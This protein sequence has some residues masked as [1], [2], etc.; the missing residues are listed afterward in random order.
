MAS[1]FQESSMPIYEYRCQSCGDTLEVLQ[2]MGS[3]KLRK[4]RKCSGKLERL[5]SRT[6]FHLKGGGWF[7]SGYSSS[8]GG[9]TKSD[10]DSKPAATEKT[11]PKKDAASPSKK[12]KKPS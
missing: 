5:V 8:S 1:R 9:V 12:P 10:S 2:K 6:S 4:C 3:G 11:K 7:D